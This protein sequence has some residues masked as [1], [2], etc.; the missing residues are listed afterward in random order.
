MISR[1]FRLNKG[2]WPVISDIWPDNKG[3]AYQM[4]IKDPVG[5]RIEKGIEKRSNQGP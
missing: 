2:S 3:Y 1:I 5:G 4:R